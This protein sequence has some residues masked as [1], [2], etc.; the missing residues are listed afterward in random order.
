MKIIVIQIHPNIKTT[1]DSFI[2]VLTPAL[3]HNSCVFTQLK[4]ISKDFEPK[5][6]M[7]VIPHATEKTITKSVLEKITKPDYHSDKS[8]VLITHDDIPNH[9]KSYIPVI[10]RFTNHDGY[11]KTYENKTYVTQFRVNFDKPYEKYKALKKLA[12]KYAQK[13]AS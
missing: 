11:I 10:V 13:Y 1:I 2:H 9:W 5:A 8:I 7:T 3:H 12:Q 4:W 6:D